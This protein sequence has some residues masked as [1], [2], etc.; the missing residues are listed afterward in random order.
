VQV[1]KVLLI[2]MIEH[3]L[4]VSSQGTEPFTGSDAKLTV[5]AYSVSVE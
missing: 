2:E 3:L 5:S 1:N 4:T